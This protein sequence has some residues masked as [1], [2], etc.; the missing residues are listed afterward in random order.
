M[1][2]SNIKGRKSWLEDVIFEW[3]DGAAAAFNEHKYDAI[4]ITIGDLTRV[5]LFSLGDYLRRQLARG[6]MDKSAAERLGVNKLRQLL[7]Y[8]PCFASS[9]ALTM[10]RKLVL[11]GDADA[12]DD[13]EEEVK[14][15]KREI[16]AY[17]AV[18]GLDTG[19]ESEER[20]QVSC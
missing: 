17:L 19:C 12:P 13:Q 7:R 1:S 15:I 6:I 4:G 3:L 14:A 8:L 20:V 5:G 2:T 11:F 9:L 10:Q 16:G 18:A